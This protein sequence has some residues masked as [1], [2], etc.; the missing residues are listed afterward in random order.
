MNVELDGSTI[1][2]IE[3]MYDTILS[4]G[5]LSYDHEK[6][7][8]F[9]AT[10]SEESFFIE[11]QMMKLKMGRRCYHT[12]WMNDFCSNHGLLKTI[13][14]DSNHVSRYVN[15]FKDRKADIIFI[16]HSSMSNTSKTWE[17]FDNIKPLI[18]DRSLVFY[19]Q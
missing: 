6:Y 19:I 10:M 4:V 8:S 7:I 3:V 15:Q 2:P 5:L 17:N 12:R 1:N 14:I 13:I 16:D 11:F 9:K 18:H